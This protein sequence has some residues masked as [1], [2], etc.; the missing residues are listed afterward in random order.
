V[1]VRKAFIRVGISL[2][3]KSIATASQ[4]EGEQKKLRH[5]GEKGRWLHRL[6]RRFIATDFRVAL[7]S[8]RVESDQ[9]PGPQ[10]EKRQQDADNNRY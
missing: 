1:K 3:K 2:A 10:R 4:A 9:K 6:V 7:G 8:I 5:H